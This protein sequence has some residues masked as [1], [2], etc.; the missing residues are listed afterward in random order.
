MAGP[1]SPCPPDHPLMIAWT[2]YKDT[3]DFKNSLHWATTDTVMR[4]ERADELGIPNQPAPKEMREQYAL[5]SMWAAFMA[6]F[7]AAGG[8]VSV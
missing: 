1:S 8:K 7:N 3:E 5:G 2:A 6:G 4:Q